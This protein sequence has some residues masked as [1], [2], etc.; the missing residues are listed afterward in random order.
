MAPRRKGGLQVRG[1][2]ETI[3]AFDQIGDEVN[4]DL[5][6]GLERA[7][8]PVR[9]VAVTHALERIQ[10]MP[11]S[12]QWAEQ[13]TVISKR[14]AL[15]YVAPVKRQTRVTTR[16]RKNL[17]E[18]LATKAMEPALDENE[19]KVVRE[20]ETVLDVLGRKHGF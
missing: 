20:V 11:R 9:A 5:R 13:K 2:R 17:A 16:K 1:L 6:E 19:E 14:S 4:D 8:E 15:V 3:R 12:P 7:A 10:N 18:Q